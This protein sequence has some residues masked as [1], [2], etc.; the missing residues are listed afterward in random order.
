M[1]TF[2]V[3]LVY[4][5]PKLRRLLLTTNNNWQ[6]DNLSCYYVLGVKHK[7][8]FDDHCGV[9]IRVIEGHSNGSDF[10]CS[11]SRFY[12]RPLPAAFIGHFSPFIS[13]IVPSH[14]AVLSWHEEGM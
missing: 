14:P 10:L 6:D 4:C 9:V 13:H 8:S 1:G 7:I 5:R 2:N 3:I 11:G 12:V